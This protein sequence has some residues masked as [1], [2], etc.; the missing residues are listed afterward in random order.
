YK[1]AKLTI[2]TEEVI[3]FPFK[4]KEKRILFITD[5]HN[6]KVEEEWIKKIP[7]VDFVIIGGDLVEKGV[8]ESLIN[9]NLSLLTSLCDKVFFVWGNNDFKFG[10][11]RL[12]KILQMWNVIILE[13]NVYSITEDEEKWSIIG[14]KEVEGGSG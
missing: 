4:I 9:H 12:K 1:T 7:P 11:K 3:N 14:L 5:L 13:D 2:I 8:P 10:E 6:R